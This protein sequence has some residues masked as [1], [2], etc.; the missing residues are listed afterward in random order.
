MQRWGRAPETY[1]ECP[2]LT[3]AVAVALNK[4][5]TGFSTLNATRREHGA[6]IKV[7]TN[8]RHFVAYA[9]PDSKRFHFDALVD[10]DDLRYTYLPAWKQLVQTDTVSGVMSAI[11][12]LNGIPSA[13]HKELL[14]DML[15]GEWGFEG[16]VLSDCDTISAISTSFHYTATVEQA[17]AIAVKSGGDLNCGPG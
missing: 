10:D 7:L 1:G 11:S 4:G 8:V 3:G 13:A 17:T 5:L 16:Y 12:G 9:G 6:Y 15:R 2:T 14:T